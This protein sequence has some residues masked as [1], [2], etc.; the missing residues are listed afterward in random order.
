MASR[1]PLRRRHALPVHRVHAG[2]QRAHGK[3]VAHDRHRSIGEE[4][5]A[6]LQPEHELALRRELAYERVVAP[7]HDPVT[8]SKLSGATAAEGAVRDWIDNGLDHLRRLGSFVD[9]KADRAR[10]QLGARAV[11]VH[12]DGAVGEPA[13]VVLAAEDEGTVGLPGDL[14]A[15]GCL[16][17]AKLPLDRAR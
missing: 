7:R 14:E 15:L 2:A 6:E 1:K 3:L 11:V 4:T 17:A 13:R 10:T 12:G 8:A 5:T 16:R 9:P